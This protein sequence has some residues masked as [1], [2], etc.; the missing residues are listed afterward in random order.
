MSLSK[1]YKL[2]KSLF[3]LTKTSSY[4]NTFSQFRSH[5]NPNVLHAMFLQ[6]G[7]WSLFHVP[8]F[9]LA[10]PIS[11]LASIVFFHGA[12]RAVFVSLV[13]TRNW[14]RFECVTKLTR[15]D[16]DGKCSWNWNWKMSS[17]PHQ[18]V[19]RISWMEVLRLKESPF[20]WFRWEPSKRPL[21]STQKPWSVPC[22]HSC[23]KD[24]TNYN[25]PRM[26]SNSSSLLLLPLIP[27]TT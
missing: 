19:R 3:F 23:S 15:L 27:P 7:S 25:Q 26:K 22:T 14:L 10:L 8:P 20:D 13:F 4:T 11:F 24:T 18:N 2:L 16:W 5:R 17:L 1:I 21:A 12:K 9:G 6:G